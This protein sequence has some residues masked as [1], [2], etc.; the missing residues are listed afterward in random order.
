[1]LENEPLISC[2]C[3]TNHRIQL[4]RKAILNF[5]NQS[6]TSKELI[7]SIPDNDKLTQHVVDRISASSIDRIKAITRNP[8]VSLGAARNEAIAN[9]NGEYICIWDDDDW[10]HQDR[11]LVQYNSISYCKQKKNG[12]V[13]SNI[14]IFDGVTR[15][16]YVS[17][18]YP[19][20]NTLLCEKQ[21]L[22]TGGYLNKDRGEDSK[23]VDLLE[24]EKR[25]LHLSDY[26]HLYIYIYHGTNTWNY[27]HFRAF[28]QRSILLDQ[29]VTLKIREIIGM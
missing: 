17:F 13:L 19:W 22:P 1:M 8:N 11:L 21:Y 9:S 3:I 27:T 20:E 18:H 16:A 5:S 4:L 12:S 15:C 10:Y 14:I 6:Y 25:L 23:I 7:I 24:S 29:V 26:P 28:I 2:I